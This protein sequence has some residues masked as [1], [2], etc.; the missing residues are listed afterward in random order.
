VT[1]SGRG[2]DALVALRGGGELVWPRSG[3]AKDDR[4]CTRTWL[5][6]CQSEVRF[7]RVSDRSEMHLAH[8][9][10]AESNRPWVHARFWP[11]GTSG[12]K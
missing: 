1:S 9:Q 8:G 2:V 7:P 4:G 6:E 11:A 5:S 12:V 10:S 3:D